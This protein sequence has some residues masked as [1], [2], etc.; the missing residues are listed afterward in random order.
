MLDRDEWHMAEC[1]MDVPYWSLC[2]SALHTVCDLLT[3]VNAFCVFFLLSVHFVFR[4]RE[5]VPV[6]S[7]CM[8]TSLYV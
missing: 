5:R 7:P 2:Y 4:E 8:L 3:Q 1:E 6:Y